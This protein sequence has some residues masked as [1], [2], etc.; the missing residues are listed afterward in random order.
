MPRQARVIVANYP[1]HII[2]RGHN[3]ADVFFDDDDY[4]FYLQNLRTLKYAFDVKVYAYCLMKNHVHL[5]INPGDN[6]SSIGLFMKR[7]A[8]RQTRYINKKYDRSG[9]LWESRY[10]SSLI[11]TERYLLACCRYVEMNPVRSK[12]T[13]T[14]LQYK[15]SSFSERLSSPVK[16]ID[17]CPNFK[18][19]SKNPIHKQK[20]WSHFI[21]Y[22]APQAE[23]DLITSAINRSQI[24]GDKPFI[25]DISNLLGLKLP[26][27]SRGRPRKIISNI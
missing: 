5:I 18:N 15:W 24:T 16:W 26:E 8:G 11:E 3:R 17:P 19:F 27:R 12:I 10:R 9:T 21:N 4:D 1:H 23:W 20:E 25:K 14:V 13:K 7:L 6:T 22:P 2:Q